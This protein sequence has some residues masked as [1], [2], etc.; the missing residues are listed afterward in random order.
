MKGFPKKL[1]S[2]ED[3]QNIIDDFGYTD[4]IK[5]AYQ[6]LL[7]TD[8]HYVFDKELASESDRTGPAP[9][10]K[11]LK[12]KE[13]DGTEKIMQYELIDNPNSKLK[14]LGFTVSEVEEVINKC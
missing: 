4:E 1:N 2:K 8:N 5:R 7:D 10:Y 3:Y 14:E 11:V 6:A 13:M 12:E 9:D